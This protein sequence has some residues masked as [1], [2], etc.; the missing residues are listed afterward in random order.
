MIAMW[1]DE[2]NS[3]GNGVV[4]SATRLFWKGYSVWSIAAVGRLLCTTVIT[5][6]AHDQ[7]STIRLS[8]HL[9]HGSHTVG[10]VESYIVEN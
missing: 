9:D 7:I 1:V 8:L 3:N 5:L 6:R 4:C 10:L 2:R